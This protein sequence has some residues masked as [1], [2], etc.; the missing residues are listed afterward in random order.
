M[1]VHSVE[2]IRVSGGNLKCPYSFPLEMISYLEL[3]FLCTGQRSTT[4]FTMAI[5]DLGPQHRYAVKTVDRTLR[6]DG[7]I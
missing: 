4:D 6:D 5:D 7:V 3:D 2:P 1:E